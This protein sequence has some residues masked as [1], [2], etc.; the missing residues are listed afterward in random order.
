MGWLSFGNPF[1]P[2]Q[3]YMAPAEFT[4][5]GYRGFDW[6]QLDLLWQTAFGM[7]YGLFTSAPFLLLALYPPAWFR[8]RFRIVNNREA[9]C[10]VIFCLLF[11]LFCAANQYGRMQ[12]NTGIRHVL[13]VTPFLFLL[14]AGVLLRMPTVLAAFVGIVTTYWSWCLAMYRD[15]EYGLGV[16]ESLVHV[17]LEGFRLPWLTTLE[18]MGY[19]PSGALA[20]PLLVLCGV[21]VWILW[22]AVPPVIPSARPFYT[23]RYSRQS[24]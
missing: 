16:F 6:P 15:V 12:F 17:T 11:F 24:D 5:F 8:G 7:R 23:R 13:P 9:W 22:R 20:M 10:I 18:R 4:H 19:F 21:I 2:A 1:Y 14:A 3:H